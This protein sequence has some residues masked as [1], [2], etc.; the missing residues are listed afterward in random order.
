MVYR[1]RSISA[2]RLR[3]PQSIAK[4]Q[5]NYH[6]FN[7]HQFN[8]HQFTERLALALLMEPFVG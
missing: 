3:S 4:P 8:Y 6:Q 2:S 1:K 5:F 7:Y